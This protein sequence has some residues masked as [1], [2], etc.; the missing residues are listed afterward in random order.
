MKG[1]NGLVII[2]LF[3]VV[4]ILYFAINNKGVDQTYLLPMNFK[5]CVVIYY[6]EK[7]A[8]PL[9]MKNNEI[10]YKVPKDGIIY[11]S[12]P[13]EFGWVNNEKSG[14]F[15]L[16][17]FYVD[18]TGKK[19]EEL[20]QEEIRFGATGSVQEEGKPE[21]KHYYQIFGSKDVENQGCPAVHP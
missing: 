11:T 20:P 6:G 18:E 17:A 16:S 14:E 5:G 3:I 7:E 15:Q 9:K 12:S 13:Q 10:I 21:R 1:K 4:G 19:I 2:F 8:P